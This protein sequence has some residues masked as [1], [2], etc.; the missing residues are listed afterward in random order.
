MLFAAPFRNQVLRHFLH[1][2]QVA[3][4]AIAVH[5]YRNI[6]IELG[7]DRIRLFLTQI[8]GNAR[9]AQHRPGEAERHGAFGGDDANINGAL[10]PDA[11][12]REQGLV[13]VHTGGEAIREILDEIKQ[14][15]LPVAVQFTHLLCAAPF[16]D[17]VLRHTIRQVA[18]D[19][20]WPII[21]GVHAGT[22]D[23]LVTVHQI[24]AFA[25]AVQEDCHGAD[26]EAV[27][28]QPHQMVEDAGDLIEH[29][30]DILRAHR[31]RDGEQ[32]FD[33]HH[34]GVFVAHHGH[35]VEA[36]HVADALIER[37]ALGELLGSPMQQ[38]DMRVGAFN[39]FAIHLKHQAQHPVGRRVLRTEIQGH[40]AYF[41]HVSLA[42]RLGWPL[43]AP[44][45]ADHARNQDP[46]FNRDGLVHHSLLVRV[47]AHLDVPFERKILAERMTDEAVV[48]QDAT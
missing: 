18:V 11:I 19:A 32:A 31:R 30:A 43:R 4:V 46:G 14:R 48:G 7:I 39:D 23:R 10:F 8:P 42:C 33:R 28:T 16:R 21:V 6:E 15:A 37:F 35:I 41:R 25:K 2:D 26:V 1:P 44:V 12:V 45:I 24:F 29:H 17:Q 5:A 38:T 40:V 20:P 13:F 27:R 3:I 47:I 22:R 34:I 9:T 36:V